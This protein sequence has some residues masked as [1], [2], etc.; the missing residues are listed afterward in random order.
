MRNAPQLLALALVLLAGGCAT[1][2]APPAGNAAD[3]RPALAPTPATP[4]VPAITAPAAP[5]GDPVAAESAPEVLEVIT[6][7][8]S[9]YA[10]SLTGRRTAS[11]ER[12]DPQQ[13][14]AAHRSLPF[15]TI[16]RVTNPANGN[17]V[18]VRVI[19]RGP[20]TRGRVLDV[21]RSAAEALGMIRRGIAPVHIEVLSRGG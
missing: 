14:V 2:L 3:V 17:S 10:N 19:D 7:I 12:Y 6:G 9:Y 4:V 8:A 15:G 5:L 1:R 20:F 21:S 18:E 11:G 13:L 16:L